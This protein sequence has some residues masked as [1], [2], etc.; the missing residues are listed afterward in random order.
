VYYPKYNPTKSNYDNCR[1]ENGGYGGLVSTTFDTTDD[2]IRFY[3]ALQ[4]AKGPSLGTN[5]TLT[6]VLL[7][8]IAK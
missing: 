2:A 6:Y 7:A 5:F 8:G 1:R 4:T 3:D